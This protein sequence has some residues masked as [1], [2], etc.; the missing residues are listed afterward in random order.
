METTFYVD[1]VRV[2]AVVPVFAYASY[3]DIRERRVP[4]RTW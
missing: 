3:L 2:L 1:A 4:H